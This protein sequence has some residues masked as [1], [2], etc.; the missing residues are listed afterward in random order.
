MKVPIN[1]STSQ[2]EIL[3]EVPHLLR[4]LSQFGSDYISGPSAGFL[5]ALVHQMV[6]PFIKL[7]Y[8]VH[9]VPGIPLL[10]SLRA[11]Q[12]TLVVPFRA[13]L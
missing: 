1:N 8:L 5:R 11:P 6:E 9:C 2:I 13:L 10:H 12:L 7:L 3:L 4:C